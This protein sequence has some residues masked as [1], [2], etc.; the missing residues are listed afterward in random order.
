MLVL[1]LQPG[2]VVTIDNFGSHEAY[3]SEPLLT[4]WSPSLSPAANFLD[5]S[6]TES[7]VKFAVSGKLAHRDDGEER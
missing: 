7:A 4:C 1:T 5:L 6:P 2:D 3:V